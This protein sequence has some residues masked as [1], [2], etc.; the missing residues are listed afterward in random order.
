MSLSK[1]TL[2]N[3]VKLTLLLAPFLLLVVFAILNS[4]VTSLTSFD[5]FNAV[6]NSLIDFVAKNSLFSWYGDLIALL[7][8]SVTSSNVIIV[9]YPCY[10]ILVELASLVLDVMLFLPRAISQWLNKL[11][12]QD[13]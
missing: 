8:V 5:Y 9:Y 11:G 6:Q 3:I 7:G 13:L 1:N 2:R 12:G 10:V 4:G